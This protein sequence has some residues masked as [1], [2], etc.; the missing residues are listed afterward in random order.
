M[1]TDGEQQVVHLW[2]EKGPDTGRRITI[3]P[4]GARV[5]RSSKNDVE[6]TDES[7][8]RFHCRFYF[9]AEG[10]LCVADL[11]STNETLVNGEAATDRALQLGDQIEIGETTLRVMQDQ[12]HGGATLPVPAPP[13]PPAGGVKIDLGL[14]GAAAAAPA[15]GEASRGGLGRWIWVIAVA[16]VALVAA[17][18]VIKLFQA[19]PDEPVARPPAA[20]SAD[21]S[22]VFE[23]VEGSPEN[24][25]RYALRLED[26]TLSLKL[27]DLK[28]NR[29]LA[30]QEKKISEE[31]LRALGSKLED[32]GFFGLQ[33]SYTGMSPGLWYETELSITLGK[34]AHTVLVRNRVEPEVFKKVREAIEDFARTEMGLAAVSLPPEKLREMAEQAVQ[35]GRKLLD[36][37][38]VAHGNL[39]KAVQSFQEAVWYLETLEPKPPYYADAVAGLE[40]SK[41]QLQQR[42]DDLQF[43]ADRAVMVR[44]WETAARNLRTICELVPAR[45]DERHAKA[46]KQLIDVERRMRR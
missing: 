13:P 1:T 8:S 36:E 33:E 3:P 9:N 24:I 39:A 35:L 14:G 46:A 26:R 31:N 20:T 37:Q 17:A 18:V 22:I 45:D 30:P 44:D 43:Q 12:L 7:L 40:E 38:G 29:H 16:A 21:V 41:R 10:R 23:K 32:S 27:D 2:V 6:L 19:G 5:G 42:Y 28:D 11:G 34:R 4:Q 25:F 15:P